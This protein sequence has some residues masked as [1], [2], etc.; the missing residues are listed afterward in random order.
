MLKFV[1]PNGQHVPDVPFVLSRVPISRSERD[2]MLASQANWLPVTACAATADELG[3]ATVLLADGPYHL[4][5]ATPSF[6]DI[7]SKGLVQ[8]TADAVETVTL[9]R[10]YASLLQI[11]STDI[12]PES[13]ELTR[14]SHPVRFHPLLLSVADALQHSFEGC[15][16]VVA[17][18]HDNNTTDVIDYTAKARLT[19]GAPVTFRGRLRPVTNGMTLDSIDVVR[20]ASTLDGNVIVDVPLGLQNCAQDIAIVIR[21]SGRVRAARI[22]TRPHATVQLPAGD[23]VAMASQSSWFGYVLESQPFSV[24]PG[25]T[26]RVELTSK[27]ATLQR[28]RL[29]LQTPAGCDPPEGAVISAYRDDVAFAS[30]MG[31]WVDPH[32]VYLPPGT[33][34]VVVKTERFENASSHLELPIDLMAEFSHCVSFRARSK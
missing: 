20:S 31:K 18:I 10:V 29:T 9:D 33:Y 17:C 13:V 5:L 26:C 6:V 24:S 21:S 11:A 30:W 23:Y 12:V 7:R 1:D 8:L 2:R 25:T 27:F 34:R 19:D 32:Y 28:V 14:T 4:V 22:R 15:D 16:R 3:M